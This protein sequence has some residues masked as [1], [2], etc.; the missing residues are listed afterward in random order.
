MHRFVASCVLLVA[1][2]GSNA[3]PNPSPT[4]PQPP[5]ENDASYELSGLREWAIIG[6][7]VDAGNETLEIS[8]T[9]PKGTDFIDGWLDG[10]A[11]F[12]FEKSDG[13]FFASVDV[14]QLGPGEYEILIAADGDST[15]FAKHAFKRS[16]PLYVVVT[17]DWDDADTTDEALALQDDL[18]AEHDELLLTHFVGPYTFTDPEVSDDREALLVNWLK[19]M[20]DDHSDEI[21]L[22]IHPY[23]NFVEAAGGILGIADIEC[24]TTESTVKAND[25]TGYTIRCSAYSDEDFTNLLLAADKLFE[26][27]GLGKP[28]SFRAGG[29]TAELNTMRS[30]E[31]AGYV[32][33][34]SANNWMRMEE[35]NAPF[36]GTLYAWNK[37]HW[38]S[39]G[40]TSQPY[41]PSVDDILVTGDETIGVLEVPDNGILVD[42]VE[43]Y[44]MIE[45]FEANWDGGLLATPV[46]Y[47][48][49]YHPSNFNPE[50][51]KRITDTLTH[52]DQFLASRDQGPVIYGRL[53][54]MAKVWKRAQ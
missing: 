35:W 2:G 20:R 42:Y 31:A 34:T 8:V 37:E 28:T 12:R 47:S 3:F 26:E 38:A 27:A 45:I 44:E 10:G 43:T 18:H 52:V 19:G 5:A 53:S 39:I 29:W 51:K 6:N 21:G 1:C 32:A 16:H 25:L 9:A 48:I 14:S 7:E 4:P 30:L 17:T 54:D 11:G 41:Y 33:D 24:N 36:M 23:C 15:A 49:G 40:D 50:Y 46:N 13:A 22:H